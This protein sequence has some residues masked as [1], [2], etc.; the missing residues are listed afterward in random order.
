MICAQEVKSSENTRTKETGISV[1]SRSKTSTH[2]DSNGQRIESGRN[3]TNY[4]GVQGKARS[5]DGGN[6]LLSERGESSDGRNVLGERGVNAEQQTTEN[7]NSV[8]TDAENDAVKY[9]DTYSLE[10]SS[11]GIKSSRDLKFNSDSI[12]NTNGKAYNNVTE[13]YEKEVKNN[14]YQNRQR[15]S[16]TESIGSKSVRMANDNDERYSQMPQ[17][18]ESIP[19][20]SGRTSTVA[21]GKEPVYRRGIENDKN[22]VG[23]SSENDRGR[24][25]RRVENR[26]IEKVCEDKK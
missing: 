16:E 10:K 18:S 15:G 21:G 9:K 26:S 20:D 22:G 8:R 4:D 2:Q 19:V 1:N 3:G 24:T 7:V 17:S 14:G 5:G 25:L 6:V 11:S 13:E 12:D 23:E